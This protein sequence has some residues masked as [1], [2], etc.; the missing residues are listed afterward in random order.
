MKREE[1]EEMTKPDLMEHAKVQGIELDAAEKKGTMIDKILG[2]FV[3][4]KAMPARRVE[5][6]LP[7]IGRLHTLD[8]KPVD[9]KKYRVTIF[10]TETDKSDVDLIVNGHNVRIRRGAEVILMEPYVEVLRNA[11]VET[12]SQDPD[13]GVRSA[14]KMM[15]YPHSAIPV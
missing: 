4:A 7:A 12:M 9:A 1:L 14:Q 5:E 6:K 10:A 8:G 11:V 13:T 3:Q 2:E 15:V